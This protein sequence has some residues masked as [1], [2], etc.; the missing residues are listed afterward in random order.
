LYWDE[1]R[2]QEA[3]RGV[4]EVAFS[5]ILSLV[6]GRRNKCDVRDPY[7]GSSPFP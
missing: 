4:L 1:S 2:T 6:D 5:T 3:F 7:F